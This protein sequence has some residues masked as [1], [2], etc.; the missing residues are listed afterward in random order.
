MK[1]IVCFNKKDIYS[2][3]RG[4]EKL[5]V[6]CAVIYGSLPPGTKLGMAAKFNDPSD[7]CKV[8]VATDAV[9]MGLNLNI[10]RIIFYSLTKLQIKD[11]GEK[12]MEVISVSQA[13]QIAGRAGRYNTQWETG[14]VTCFRQEEIPLMHELLSKTPEDILQAGLH[15][16]YDQI[17]TYAYHLPHATMANL[18]DIF[19]SLST[20]DDSLYNLCQFDDFKFIADMIEHIKLPLKAKYTLC[21]APLNRRM[22][23]VCTMFLKITRQFSRGELITFDWICHQVGWPFRHQIQFSI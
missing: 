20:V 22:P 3:S 14:H 2:V 18:V 11:D 7:P 1:N 16:T 21:C 19:I 9:G 13:L 23:F 8:L 17:E 4:L 6:E 10:R 5:G 15:P 12:V